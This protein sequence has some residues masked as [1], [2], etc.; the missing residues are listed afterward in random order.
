MA[1]ESECFRWKTARSGQR[2]R[3]GTGEYG[4]LWLKAAP[5]PPLWLRSNA[6]GV[7]TPL[8]LGGR[9][10][11]EDGTDRPLTDEVGLF[12][13]RQQMGS[14]EAHGRLSLGMRASIQGR[15]AMKRPTVG[16]AACRDWFWRVM[17]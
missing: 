4:S 3:H 15:S 2:D 16:E 7:S 17:A 6:E 1:P 12:P 5:D 8:T 11:Q 10:P 13:C 9:N 14:C